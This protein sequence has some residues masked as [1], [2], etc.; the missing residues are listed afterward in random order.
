[1]AKLLTWIQTALLPA[2]GP[3]G[4]FVVALLDSSVLSLPEVNELLVVAG[5]A[6]QPRLAWLFVL[7]STLG[8]LAGCLV[9][10][11]LGRRG[12]EAL[13]AK[14]FGRA[15][16]ERTRVAYQHWKFWA[17]ALP[18]V[19]PPPVPLKVFVFAAGA[20]GMSWR[21][22]SLTIVLARGLRYGLWAV[23]GV[24]Y[25]RSAV[26]TLHR[27]D[28]WIAQHTQVV[29]LVSVSLLLLATGTW[30]ARRRR[31]QAQEPLPGVGEVD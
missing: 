5:S 27:F 9:L 8:S 22:F 3:W 16:M 21:R 6:A 10:W 14:R 20:F 19:L 25:G 11:H 18:A 31:R 29:L 12:G 7:F 23:L 26:T 4:L 13:L 17:L 30:L 2:M 1:M 24:L 15:R 28:D